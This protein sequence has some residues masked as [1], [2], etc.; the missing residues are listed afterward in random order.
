[1]NRKPPPFSFGVSILWICASTF[2]IIN[3]RTQI[4]FERRH[5]VTEF[6]TY[7]FLVFWIGMLTISIWSFWMSRKGRR[8]GAQVH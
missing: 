3:T 2:E 4:L 1:M 8:S 7:A 5:G 6:L